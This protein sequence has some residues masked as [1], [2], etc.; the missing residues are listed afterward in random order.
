MRV[1][2]IYSGWRL[3]SASIE[4]FDVSSWA[5]GRVSARTVLRWTEICGCEQGLKLEET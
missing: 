1:G 4:T 2:V 3:G 5:S